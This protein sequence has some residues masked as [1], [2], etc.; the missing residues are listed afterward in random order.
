MGKWTLTIIG[1]DATTD[2]GPAFN[3]LVDNL[4]E[5]GHRVI[6]ARILTDNGEHAL[7]LPAMLHEGE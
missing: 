7:D 5:V 2:L 6:G 3:T 4:N 1:Q